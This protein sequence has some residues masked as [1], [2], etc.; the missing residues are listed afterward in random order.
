MK[1]VIIPAGVLTVALGL[2]QAWEGYNPKVYSDPIGI[3][4]SCYG[5]T[6]P[7]NWWGRHFTRS[8]CKALLDGDIGNAYAG[9]LNCVHRPMPDGLAAALT[10]FTYNAGQGT[11]PCAGEVRLRGRA[12][13]VRPS[14]QASSGD[15]A[16]PVTTTTLGYRRLI[17]WIALFGV[18]LVVGGWLKGANWLAWFLP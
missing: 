7:E 14:A 13:I 3:P 16:V 1:R 5:H 9:V 8:E 4:T 11:V 12:E 18:G 15:A 10:D 2:V 17:G 6:G